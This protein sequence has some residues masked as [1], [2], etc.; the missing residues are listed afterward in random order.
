MGCQLSQWQI[1][2]PTRKRTVELLPMARQALIGF[3][4]KGKAALAFD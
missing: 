2:S 4:I 1:L 3:I